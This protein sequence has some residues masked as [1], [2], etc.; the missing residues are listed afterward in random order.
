MANPNMR[1]GAPSLNPGGRPKVLGEITELARAEC[2]AAISRLAHLRDHA[3]S[4]QVQA[5]ACEAL[6]SRGYGRPMQPVAV[7]QVPQIKI[8]AAPDPKVVEHV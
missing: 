2:P 1:K 5:Y 3:R 6:L 4:E 7:A 8:I